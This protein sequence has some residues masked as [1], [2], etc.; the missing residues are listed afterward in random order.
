MD[1]ILTQNTMASAFYFGEKNYAA[2]IL[3]YLFLNVDFVSIAAA[4][5]RPKIV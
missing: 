4:V 2:P 5:A 3:T 1:W